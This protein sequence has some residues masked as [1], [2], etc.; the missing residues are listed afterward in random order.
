MSLKYLLT[1]LF[2][3]G[4][5]KI[6]QMNTTGHAITNLSSHGMKKLSNPIVRIII[7]ADTKVLVQNDIITAKTISFKPCIPNHKV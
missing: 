6:I 7:K 3:L 4:A 2:I 1:N 5:K